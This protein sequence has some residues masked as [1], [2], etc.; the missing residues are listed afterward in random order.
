MERVWAGVVVQEHNVQVHTSALR[1]ALAEYREGESWIVTVSG[2]G[3]LL[4]G[5]PE[6]PAVTTPPPN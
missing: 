1:K 3:C 2:R 4:L 6:P 5:A